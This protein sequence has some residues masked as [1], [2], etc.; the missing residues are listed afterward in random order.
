MLE[1]RTAAQLQT[2]IYLSVYSPVDRYI[3]SYRIKRDF[4]QVV[5]MP[6]LQYGCTTCTL[7]KHIEKK[8]DENYTRMSWTNLGSNISSCTATYFL[9]HEPFK[10]DEQDMRDTVG[11]AMTNT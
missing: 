8:L 6:I 3:Y 9:S 4:F 1:W 10:L 2:Y 11:E 7:T 5:T